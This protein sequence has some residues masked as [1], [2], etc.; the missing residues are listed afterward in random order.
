VADRFAPVRALLERGT[1]EGVFPGAVLQVRR[2]G[3]VL[4]E[5]AVGRTRTDAPGLPVRASTFFDMASVSKVAGTTA[6][7]MRYLQAGRMTLDDRVAAYVPGLEGDKAEITL[8]HLLTHTSGLPAWKGLFEPLLPLAREKRFAEA[9][10]ELVR[11]AAR[12]GLESAPGTRSVYSD[13]GFI[14][15]GAALEAMGGARLDALWRREVAGPLGLTETFYIDLAGPRPEGEFAATERC[16]WRGEVLE[17][18]VHDENTYVSG[19]IA[20]HAGLFSTARGVGE[21]ASALLAAQAGR[22]AWLSQETVRAFWRPDPFGIGASYAH[23]WDTPSAEGSQSGTRLAGAFGH[24]GY[25]GTSLW[26]QP[27]RRLAIVLL[28]NR[29]HPTREN[30]RIKTFRP[31]L[32]DAVVEALGD[33]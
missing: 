13:L 29:V 26:I 14:L 4:C 7:A 28:T 27:S 30:A 25:T 31:A 8:R 6:V 17:A 22:S 32:H 3:E 24:T 12:Q 1:R 20:G 9:R 10:A 11:A 23:G 18:V 2:E 5:A 33:L 19:G 16:A 21:I 15:L